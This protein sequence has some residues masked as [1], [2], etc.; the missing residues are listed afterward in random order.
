ME[1]LRVSP[2][3]FASASLRLPEPLLRLDAASDVRHPDPVQIP[4]SRASS[5]LHPHRSSAP[6]DRHP[7]EQPASLPPCPPSRSSPARQ[8]DGPLHPGTL[9]P[10]GDRRL[11]LSR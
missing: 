1:R 7:E 6:A 10:K 8:T 9:L 11:L 3:P 2:P 5:W 4:G